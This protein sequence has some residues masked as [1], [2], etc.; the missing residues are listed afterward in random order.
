MFLSAFICEDNPVQL[1]RMTK[2]VN[3]FILANGYAM[4]IGLATSNP[5]ALLAY[6]KKNPPQS[7]LYFLDVDLHHEI[8]GID[9]AMKIREMDISGRIVFVTTYSELAYLTFRYRL[10]VMDYI[11]KDRTGLVKKAVHECLELAYQHYPNI[12]PARESFQIKSAEGVRNVFYEEVMFFETHARS[13]KLILH[14]L[15]G[16]IEFRGTL[17]EMEKLSPDFCRCHNAHVVHT[18][19]IKSVNKTQGIIE[20]VNGETTYVTRRKMK[21]L[22]ARLTSDE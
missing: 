20:M 3:D 16:R 4:Q 14:T 6:L 11:V 21:E 19:N 7:A 17:D 1:K 10:E 9:L 12:L 18:K 5:T 8:N 13:H 15:N 2:I 22:I